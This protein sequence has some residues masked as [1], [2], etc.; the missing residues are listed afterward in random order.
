MDA[1]KPHQMRFFREAGTGP[2]V[3]CLHS[4]ASTSAQWRS[5]MDQLSPQ[6]RVLAPDLLGAGKGPAWPPNQAVSLGGEVRL[7]ETV[8]AGAGNPFVLVGYFYGAAG[9]GGRFH[10]QRLWLGQ[11]PVRRSHTSECIPRPGH[12]HSLHGR[13]ALAGIVPRRCAVAEQGVAT[14]QNAGVPGSWPHGP[15]DASRAR[16]WRDQAFFV[17]ALSPL[18]GCPHRAGRPRTVQDRS[19]S[20]RFFLLLPPIRGR[21]PIQ[22]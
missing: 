20:G 17:A 7:L 16:E 2:G 19:K 14:G 21:L 1:P 15:G 13:R 11:C 4:N 6:F 12:A 5:L 8:F 22:R 10:G 18:H 9:A 3:V